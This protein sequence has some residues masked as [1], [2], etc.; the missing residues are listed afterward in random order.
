VT[1]RGRV[2]A[3]FAAAMLLLL[4]PIIVLT[5]RSMGRSLLDELDTGLR[6]RA[7]GEVNAPLRPRV[8]VPDRRLQE[9]REAV[10]QLL[11]RD[12]R[13]LRATASFLAPPLLTRRELAG[14]SRPMFFE[15]RLG[16]GDDRIRLLAVPVL[17]GAN[18]GDVLVVG[19]SMS[20][21]ADALRSLLRVLLIGGAGAVVF[22]SLVGW[23]LARWAFRPV[24]RMTGQAAAITASGLDHRLDV[25]PTKD[26]VQRL[27]TTLNGML[28][29]VAIA[30]ARERTFL[31]QA[32]HEL[33]TPL[34]ALRAETELALRRPR[35]AED[36][37]ASLVKVAA[38][39][40]RMVRLAEDLLVLARAGGGRLPLRRTKQPVAQILTAVAELFSAPCALRRVAL[41]V[42]C[43]P[44]QACVDP[45]R[46]R[47]ALINLVD[48][49]L[50][51][52]PPG[53]RIGLAGRR[54]D[55]R[56]TIE[57]SDTG[58]G[59][60]TAR[61]GGGGLGLRIVRTVAR[62][63]GGG[64]DIVDDAPAGT[65]VRIVLNGTTADS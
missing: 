25:P 17:T 46:L 36:L 13:V 47:Q 28:D 63:H 37:H 9:P 26:E 45:D 41:D 16:A 8:E 50:R 27:A 62:A 31:E 11:D 22:A 33:R 34:A 19:A 5:H 49:S 14:I 18:A 54:T 30:V 61:S 51:H 65:T 52:T 7:A 58:P 21:R 38:E 29:R 15:R 42:D 40:D 24:E 44:G 59:F 20:D 1:I 55:G 4:A 10:D 60:A 48:N 32:S 12:G 6:F 23:L 57:V 64:V 43:D 53:G 35:P 39:T 56:W 2:T 3:A